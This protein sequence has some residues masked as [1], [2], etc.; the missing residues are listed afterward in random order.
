MRTPYANSAPLN[1][2]ELTG[3]A[4]SHV[5]LCAEP[6]CTLHCDALLA[7]QAMRLAALGDGIDMLPVSS[8]R[9]FARQLE[10]W[11]AKYSGERALR[12]RDNRILDSA[13]LSPAE[14]VAAILVWSALPGASRHHWGSDCDLIDR[15]TAPQ[16][17]P[18]ELLSEDF[19]AGGRY[20]ALNDWLE[21]RA[22]DFGFFRPYDRDRGG[23]QPEP[24]HLSYAPV[25]AP[26]LTAMSPA[27]LRT[28]LESAPLA[29]AEVVA[30]QLPELFE[31]YVMAVAE[32]PHAARYARALSRGATPA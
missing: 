23:V 27:L 28:A 5:R 32:V 19:A 1:E 20:A 21:A 10:I 31:R 17:G 2:L 14:R 8:F 13:A 30:V 25:A 26:A 3:R 22:A 6:P 4:S 29:G 18:I 9:D 12:G 7:L 16:A 15:R 24:W 11:N